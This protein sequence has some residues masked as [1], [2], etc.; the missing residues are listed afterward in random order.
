MN[1]KFFW[2]ALAALALPVLLRLIWLFPGFNFPR[3]IATPDYTNLKM[4]EAPVST[5][6]VEAIKKLGGVV[7]IDYAHTNQFQPTEIQTLTDS[8]TLRG[9]R[10]EFASDQTLLASQLKYASAYVVISPSVAFNSE[11]LRLIH[12][13]E[14]LGGRLAVFTDATRGQVA[15]DFMGNPVGNSPDVNTA[16]PL[17]EPFGISI[18]GDYL[19]DLT[20]NE[21]NFRNVYLKSFGKSDLTWGLGKIALYGTHSVETDSGLA[22]LVGDDKTLS[23]TTDAQPSTDPKQDWAAA[24]LSKDGNVFAAGDFTFLTPPYNTVGDNST[25]INNIADFLLTGQRKNMLANFPY[26]FNE[27][28]VDILATSKVQLTAGMTGALSK[29][30]AR[31][32]ATDTE[33]KVVKD[34]PPDNNLIVLGT[35]SSSDDLAKY[36]EPFNVKL[37][38]TSEYVEIPQFGKLGRSGNGV[39]LFSNS[40]KGVTLILLADSVDDVT[41]LME[42]LSSGDLTSCV[43]QGDV[44]VCSIGSG[45]SFS[46]GATPSLE[47]T[48][49]PG[50]IPVTAT[51]SG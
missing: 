30:Q 20:D 48:P 41:T 29:L 10:V 13:F 18:N 49:I 47:A 32:A 27:S 23:S 3:S 16:N 39:L 26:I 7:I 36:V 17:V 6:Q 8:L 51:P 44:G 14:S 1:R 11:D 2:I 15:Y 24:V 35:F 45:G 28:T 4:P 5:V 42:T 21:G 31:L 46:E 19:Y 50:E 25:L 40:A 22:L 37:D 43:L 12:D 33:L 38:D 9:A 34:T